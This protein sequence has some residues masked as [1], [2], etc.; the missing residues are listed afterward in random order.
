MSGFA[1]CSAFMLKRPEKSGHTAKNRWVV[2]VDGFHRVVLWLKANSILLAIEGLDRGGVID[3]RNDDL[4]VV[5]IMLLF[6]DDVVSVEDARIDHR[7]AADAEDER[8]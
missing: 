5:G 4:S 7:F 8:A 6:D 3:E 2:C 1:L